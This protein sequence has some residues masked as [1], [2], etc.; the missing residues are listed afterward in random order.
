M[1]NN[2]FT[3][4]TVTTGFGAETNINTNFTNVEIALD[5]ML[6][7]SNSTDNAMSIPLDM[8][9][10]RIL[11]LPAASFSTDP[12]R[13]TDL[14]SLVTGISVNEAN[15]VAA[16]DGATLPSITVVASDKVLL[17]D[18]SSSDALSQATAQSVANLALNFSGQ[19]ND[20]SM[21]TIDNANDVLVIQ[22]VSTSTRYKITL[23]SL[24]TALGVGGGGGSGGGTSFDI[25]GATYD[26]LSFS[27]NVQTGNF[28]S[29]LVF[30]NTGTRMYVGS[31]SNNAIYQYNLSTPWDVSTA[32]YSSNS[33][34]V[35]TQCTNTMASLQVSIDGAHIYAC[36]FDGSI[37]QYDMSTA[38][39]LSTAAYASKSFNITAISGGSEQNVLF[40]PDGYS[41]LWATYDATGIIY[42]AFLDTA[43]DISTARYSQKNFDASTYSTN[44]WFTWA[45][46]GKVLLLF[47]G[48]ATEQIYQLNAGTPYRISTLTDSALTRS[49]G[50]LVTLTGNAGIRASANGQKFYAIDG[51]SGGDIYQ[52]STNFTG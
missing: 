38:W 31:Q 32:S 9:S 6:S 10:N 48:T 34:D 36:E 26:S 29:D 27:P 44:G 1:A 15:V 20:S 45:D 22:D 28:P 5:T 33:L 25:S 23:N 42:E 51:A 49:I 12:V 16:L 2:S 40:A 13:V 8:N 35:S 14:S 7:R 46:D 39:D 18:V 4:A 30:N 37:Y 43:W 21:F 3:P 24:S 41:L 11:N 19:L 47:N 50:S 52:F 17:Q